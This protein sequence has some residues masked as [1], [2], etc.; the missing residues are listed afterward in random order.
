MTLGPAEPRCCRFL[1][2]FRIFGPRSARLSD[3][4]KAGGRIAHRPVRNSF[5]FSASVRSIRIESQ[6]P[7]E[8]LSVTDVWLNFR[9][10]E[11]RHESQQGRVPWVGK[12]RRG[13][14]CGIAI[15]AGKSP[16]AA[17]GALG[18]RGARLLSMVTDTSDNPNDTGSLR[19]AVDQATSGTTIQFAPN[20][21]GTI[22]LT[23]G[24]LDINK[25]LN[26]IGPGAGTL[27]I[28]GNNNRRVF[29]VEANVA[30]SI[31]G[32]TITKGNVH[33]YIS[34]T[35]YG[36]ALYNLGTVNLNNCDISNNYAVEGA[37]GVFNYGS[38][39]LTMTNCTVSGNSVSDSRGSDAGGGVLNSAKATLT[40]LNCTISDNTSFNGGGVY[41]ISSSG[42]TTT[43]TNCTVTGNTASQSGGGVMN[44]F[45]SAG[46][47]ELDTGPAATRNG[48]GAVSFGSFGNFGSTA[49]NAG[50][51][52]TN[53]TISGN[54]AFVGGGVYDAGS[55]TTDLTACTVSN[56]TVGRG[57]GGLVVNAPL[58]G[59]PYGNATLTDTI[60]AGNN[61]TSAVASD[62]SS[63]MNV[64]GTFNL[65]GTGGSGGL[66]NGVAGNIVGV[67]DPRLARSV[68]MEGPP[69]QCPCFLAARPS[70]RATRQPSRG[71]TARLPTG[72]AAAGY[73][74]VPDAERLGDHAPSPG[75]HHDE[76]QPEHAGRPPEPAPGCQSG[77]LAQSGRHAHVRP[78]GLCH[79]PDN[80]IDV[81]PA[82]RAERYGWPSD[83]HNPGPACRGDGQR[84]R[85][86]N[87]PRVPGRLGCHG[88]PVRADDH[89][90]RGH[91]GSG[92]RRT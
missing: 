16:P 7:C 85:R 40:M 22:T 57:G 81:S 87:E 31:S 76:R 25:S 32:L 12:L 8:W 36:G 91:G 3:D 18:A 84:Q 59:G 20:V 51:V 61:T 14:G 52:L 69:R 34:N 86:G 62:I 19:Y 29:K 6:R 39:R 68:H 38:A 66:V 73:R 89:G 79:I 47:I 30:A 63:E 64:Q 75:G 58:T 26:I 5:G 43:L 54:K 46:H 9:R 2:E 83:D 45:Y 80:C 49:G 90:R 74:R 27:A 67:A 4:Y 72:H 37:G 78:D 1:R 88:V 15:P 21:T 48:G 44:V 17:A 41:N 77:K 10:S 42:A 24:T 60:I 56:N 82:A 65:I 11:I 35:E 70:A 13:R 92:W 23:N 53:C 33:G 71:P 50:L 28:S 55:A